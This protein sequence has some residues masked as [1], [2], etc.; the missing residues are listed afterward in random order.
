MQL[1][2]WPP[3]CC[4]E[5][6]RL[7][8]NP[9]ATTAPA[10]PCLRD[11]QAAA[12]LQLVAAFVGAHTTAQQVVD[13]HLA[14]KLHDGAADDDAAAPD[15]QAARLVL[16]ESQ[17]EVVAA[18]EYAHTVRWAFGSAR[19][20]HQRSNVL[21]RPPRTCLLACCALAVPP[22][23][24]SKRCRASAATCA[25]FCLRACLCRAP[26]RQVLLPAHPELGRLL[27]SKLVSIG[28]LE[29]QLDFLSNIQGSG[30]SLLMPWL[31][32]TVFGKHSAAGA[33]LS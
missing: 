9:L 24:S 22:A 14:E 32:S 10:H 7:T 8:C 26:P 25:S 27:M 5:R 15:R 12:K 1:S 23:C 4:A 11:P 31:L 13:T 16:Q 29:E 28:I 21:G 20:A 3:A 33:E 6:R 2:R 18:T 30:E 17:A 19:E